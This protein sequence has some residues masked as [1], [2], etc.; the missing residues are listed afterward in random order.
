MKFS[1][2][3]F[4]YTLDTEGRVPCELQSKKGEDM[5]KQQKRQKNWDHFI[6]IYVRLTLITLT[7]VIFNAIGFQLHLEVLTITLT[8][9]G[10]V[11]ATV[12]WAES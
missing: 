4:L 3:Q 2:R 6:Y 7:T 5:N 1:K 8:L 12:A 10:L 9:I 11:A